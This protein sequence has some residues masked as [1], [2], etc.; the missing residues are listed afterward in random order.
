MCLLQTLYKWLGLF[1]VD[2]TGD[3]YKLEVSAWIN[4]K[5]KHQNYHMR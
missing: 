4:N 1:A 5:G 2:A 3:E